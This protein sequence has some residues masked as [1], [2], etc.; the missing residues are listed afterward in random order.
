MGIKPPEMTD[1]VWDYIF[2]DGPFPTETTV[3]KKHLDHL[4]S[5][6]NY[7]YPFDIRSSGKDLIPNHLTFCVYNHAALFPEDKW[8]ASMRTNGHLMLNGKKMSKSTGNS[9]TMKGS[10][11]K[12]GA[13]VTRVVLA[14][15][16][17]GIEDAN[18]EEKN[19]NAIVLRIHTLVQ[20]CEVGVLLFSRLERGLTVIHTGNDQG[21]GQT[22][23]RTED[24]PRSSLCGRNQEL[25]QRHQGKLR[26]V[27]P[28][29]Y[30][31]KSPLTL[32]GSS[33]FYKDALKYGFFELQSARDWYR[34][35]TADAGGM[36]VDL[37]KHWIEVAALLATPIAPHF[38]EHVWSTVLGKPESIQLALWPTP[39][40][41]VDTATVEA[42]SYM[43]GTIKT[44]RDAELTLI[45]K[46]SRGKT[47]PY[48]PKKPKAVRVYVASKFPEWQNQCVEAVKE[49]YDGETQKVDDAKVREV[50]QKK[51]LLKD[52]RAMPFIQLFKVTVVRSFFHL[53]RS[54]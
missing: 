25:N 38:T 51:G 11:E 35:I 36:H 29:T 26:A 9:L 42:G 44:I 40:S 4:K 28:F 33:T 22:E 6:F 30:T 15:A 23:D 50:L 37:V 17:D 14:D 13:D 47:S 32:L 21:T 2:R 24:L 31:R 52:K 8:P 49:A 43:R 53:E 3:P 1:E 46:L 34:E 27:R 12:F 10:V 41:A 7:F 54:S 16:G 18:F 39:A 48:D 19:A 20:W 5:D 45:K